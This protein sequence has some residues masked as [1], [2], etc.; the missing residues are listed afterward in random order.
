MEVDEIHDAAPHALTTEGAIR[1]VAER[2]AQ[3][4]PEGSA[5][6]PAGMAERGREDDHH[7]DRG[8]P[9]EEPGSPLADAERAS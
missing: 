6:D 2:P 1:E 8:H 9:D 7:H 5:R 4:Q 3:D